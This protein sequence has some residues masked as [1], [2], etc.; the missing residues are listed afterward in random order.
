MIPR[1]IA[2]DHKG[3]SR[4]VLIASGA[5]KATLQ[6]FGSSEVAIPETEIEPGA[7]SPSAEPHRP[8]LMRAVDVCL[9]A[10]AHQ[11]FF[12][13]WRE[14]LV[15]LI[16][17][18]CLLLAVANAGEGAMPVLMHHPYVASLKRR[19]SAKNPALF[20]V[21]L[22]TKPNWEDDH[23]VASDYAA[24]LLHA[25]HQGVQPEDFAEWASK[26]TLRECRKAV[27]TS[28]RQARVAA[29]AH[30]E[31]REPLVAAHDVED[32]L[33]ALCDHRQQSEPAIVANAGDDERDLGPRV[34]WE[35]SDCIIACN[36]TLGRGQ[37]RV[38]LDNDL[39][40]PALLRRLADW[41]ERREAR[42]D[43]HEH[44]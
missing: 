8:A 26:K 31:S 11:L 16:P 32:G 34:N 33:D 43:E 28:R 41:F 25:L 27:A 35:D 38:P 17:A 14:K 3:P 29:N 2:D 44:A 30:V 20:A 40:L 4:L 21:R 6:N 5:P 10:D 37:F 9:G 42:S 23:K 1:H 15:A 19:P 18:Y 7:S 24:M 36:G 39:P 13:A 22:I 12:G